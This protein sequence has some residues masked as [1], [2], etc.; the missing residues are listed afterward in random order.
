MEGTVYD[1][2]RLVKELVKKDLKHIDDKLLF[3]ITAKLSTWHYPKKRTKNMKLSKDDTML[4]ELYL[5]NNYNPSTVYK[6]MLACNSNEDIQKKLMNGEISLKK[7]LSLPKHTRK[8]TQ[9]DSEMLYQ[10]KMAVQ[11]YVVR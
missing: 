11:K 8:I 6:W 1:K 7:A 9:A 10:I 2:L 4:Y 5:N 3:Q